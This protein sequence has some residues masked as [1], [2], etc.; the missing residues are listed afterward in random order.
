VLIVLALAGGVVYLALRDDPSGGSTPPTTA[1][2]PVSP[3]G[4]QD[5]DP[6]GTNGEDHAD[7]GKAIDGD[8]STAWSTEQYVNFQRDKPGVGLVLDLGATRTV[9]NVNVVAG[10]AGWGGEIYVADQPAPTLA[11][12]G[13]PHDPGGDL[14][15]EH[16]FTLGSGAK[17]RYVLLW[18]TQLPAAVGRQSLQV[19]EVT[20][21]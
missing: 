20:V 9:R 17:G 12:W 6:F 3:V 16:V 1:A 2:A 10:E 8:R 11:G 7:V 13:A 4:A 14:P 5:F 21:G 18:I 15:A 19:A